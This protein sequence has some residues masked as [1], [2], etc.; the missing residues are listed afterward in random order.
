M[1]NILE[2]VQNKLRIQETQQQQIIREK[3]IDRPVKTKIE[4]KVTEEEKEIIKGLARLQHMNVS[5]FMRY[6][7]LTKYCDEVLK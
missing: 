1:N 6:L 3:E 2:R 5:E 4:I 7:A